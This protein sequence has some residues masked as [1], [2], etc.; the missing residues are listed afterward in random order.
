MANNTSRSKNENSSCNNKS[1]GQT[2]LSIPCISPESPVLLKAEL[3]DNNMEPNL[4]NI[5]L[6]QT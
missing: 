4:P 2:F 1:N 5:H 6:I 3:F